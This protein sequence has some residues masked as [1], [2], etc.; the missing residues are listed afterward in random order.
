M[1][2]PIILTLERLSQIAR[3]SRP[4]DTFISETLSKKRASTIFLARHGDNAYNPR[5]YEP[6]AENHPKFMPIV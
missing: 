5:I 1:Y 2:M 3:I 6:K 4:A